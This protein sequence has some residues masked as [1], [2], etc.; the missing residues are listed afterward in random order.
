[1]VGLISTA[2]AFLMRPLA[3]RDPAKA[4]QQALRFLKGRLEP[5]HVFLARDEDHT[6]HHEKM[7]MVESDATISGVSTPKGG[8]PITWREWRWSGP[9]KVEDCTFNAIRWRFYENGRIAF[10][11]DMQNAAGNIRPGNLQGHRIELVTADGLLVGAWKAAFFVRRTSGIRH[12]PAT[13]LD[14]HPLLPLHFEE[15]AERQ[16]G[17]CFHT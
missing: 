10:Q 7:A 5:D 16:P 12:F 2:A 8:T 4:S 9:T 17:V 14:D 1:M 15:L 13:I 11:A 6:A 3:S